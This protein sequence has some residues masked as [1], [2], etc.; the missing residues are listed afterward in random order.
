[1]STEKGFFGF[2]NDCIS[3][4]FSFLIAIVIALLVLVAAGWILQVW[5]GNETSSEY[6][7]RF[8]QFY[9]YPEE[10]P[11]GAWARE[12]FKRITS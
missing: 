3:N 12:A 5:A 9:K 4:L 7:N 11:F 6:F 2:L 10:T 1:M 8:I